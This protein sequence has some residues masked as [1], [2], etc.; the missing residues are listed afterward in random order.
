MGAHV[1]EGG[2]GTLPVVDTNAALDERGELVGRGRN[3]GIW[4]GCKRGWKINRRDR[5]KEERT[6]ER[7]EGLKRLV[8]LLRTEQA[9][10]NVGDQDIEEGG[11]E[12][13]VRANP[14][15]LHLGAEL[16]KVSRG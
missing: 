4:E 1:I 11:D 6:S 12:G 3:T 5:D 9:N 2:P 13:G 10:G 14:F 7:F 8:E 16:R 15:K